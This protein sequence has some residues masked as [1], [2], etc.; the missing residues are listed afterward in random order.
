MISS[1]AAYILSM[2][3]NYFKPLFALSHRS[4]DQSMGHRCGHDEDWRDLQID[5]QT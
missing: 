3:V 1:S 2:Q 5:L 4:G